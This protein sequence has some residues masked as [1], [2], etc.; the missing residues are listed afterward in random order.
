MRQALNHDDDSSPN[1]ILDCQVL[2]PDEAHASSTDLEF[3]LARFPSRLKT[4]KNFRLVLMSATVNSDKL[5]NS[6]KQMGL[7]SDGAC[8]FCPQ[9]RHQ[10]LANPCLN[11]STPSRGTILSMAFEQW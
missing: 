4:A 1:T 5:L 6:F 8:V 9:E 3:I 7:K 10:E 2:T 11:Y